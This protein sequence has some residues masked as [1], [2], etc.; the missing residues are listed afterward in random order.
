MWS[1]DNIFT[2]GPF[3][4]Y[5]VTAPCALTV[6]K[7]QHRL[8]GL[9]TDSQRVGQPSGEHSVVAAP[10]GAPAGRQVEARRHG[11]VCTRGGQVADPGQRAVRSPE[12][13]HQTTL[14]RQTRL[15]PAQRVRA[16]TLPDGE[17]NQNSGGT[18]QTC[19][20]MT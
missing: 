18:I 16:D 2:L 5:P 6:G 3:H 7:G 20:V 1:Y 17:I 10:H 15:E 19:A 12:R 9:L 11:P 14:R 13:H 8:S 4:Q